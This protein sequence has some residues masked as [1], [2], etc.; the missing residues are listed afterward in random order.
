[1]L[2]LTEIVRINEDTKKTSSQNFLN[3][4][5]YWREIKNAGTNRSESD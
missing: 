4:T 5:V 2:K 1:M 3:F